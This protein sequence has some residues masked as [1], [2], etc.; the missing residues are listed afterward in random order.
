MNISLTAFICLTMLP[1]GLF[2]QRTAGVKYTVDSSFEKSD[3]VRSVSYSRVEPEAPYNA[4]TFT[5]W[6]IQK[7]QKT[8][9]AEMDSLIYQEVIRN[10]AFRSKRSMACPAAITSSFSG[11][12]VAC[13]QAEGK[14]D[15]NIYYFDLI[16][17]RKG[18]KSQWISVIRS[19]N[20]NL[21]NREVEKFIQSLK[22]VKDSFMAQGR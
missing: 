13:A 14:Q 22:P 11:Y 6:D 18:A 8:Q 4:L 21:S 16:A 9:Q 5:V 2:G 3:F 1:M 7:S 19:N 20:P 17:I 10:M 15:N 12:E